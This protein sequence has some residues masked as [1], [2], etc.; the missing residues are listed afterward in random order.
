MITTSSIIVEYPLLTLLPLLINIQLLEV[1]MITATILSIKYAIIQ[2]ALK[3]INKYQLCTKSDNNV[4]ILL[5]CIQSSSIFTR[6]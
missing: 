5:D 2:G 4:M 3:V 1:L 6:H